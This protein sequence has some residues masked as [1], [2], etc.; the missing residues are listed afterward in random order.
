LQAS[1]LAI[2]QQL[3]Q[4]ITQAVGSRCCSLNLCLLCYAEQQLMSVCAMLCRA[5]PCCAAAT[6]LEPLAD[7]LRE[8]AGAELKITVR[9]KGNEQQQVGC[10]VMCDPERVTQVM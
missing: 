7:T 5:V 9:S 6:L 1:K 3:K 8:A 2:P 10:P 4:R